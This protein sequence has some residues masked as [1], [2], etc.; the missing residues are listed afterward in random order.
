M[1]SSGKRRRLSAQETS[2]LVTDYVKEQQQDEEENET[3]QPLE[4]AR[5]ILAAPCGVVMPNLNQS[6][7]QKEKHHV[8]VDHQSSPPLPCAMTNPV[9]SSIMYVPLGTQLMY[10]PMTT[11]SVPL[12]PLGDD[13]P[14]GYRGEP[15][16]WS[17]SA[18]HGLS[19]EEQNLSPSS[20]NQPVQMCFP[21]TSLTSQ[22]GL[23]APIR[24]SCHTL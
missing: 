5:K 19:A 16:D 20:C 1:T 7:E 4:P 8:Q 23:N 10:V 3:V 9:T 2:T 18:V 22:G 24:P 14:W 12:K 6:Q 15:R 17:P 13:M 21:I 11:T